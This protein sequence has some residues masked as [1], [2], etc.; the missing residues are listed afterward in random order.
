MTGHV[1]LLSTEPRENSVPNVIQTRQDTPCVRYASSWNDMVAT[2]ENDDIEL[3]LWKRGRISPV[4][5]IEDVTP[6][7][8]EILVGDKDDILS[9]FTEAFMTSNWS[10]VFHEIV[11]LDVQA[12]LEAIE[13]VVPGSQYRLKLLALS[14]DACR[15]F[16]QDRTFQRL[17]ITYRGRGAVW[18]HE[19][20]LTEHHATDMECVFLRGKRAGRDAKILH[21]SPSFTT[22]HPPRLVMVI[23]TL[24]SY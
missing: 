13:A 6:S 22:G 3:V 10:A 14:D 16:H 1:N 4:S 5:A 12:Y 9:G 21:K 15:K 7:E 19:D 2:A 8:F 18:R 23:D 11:K 24:P 20:S 17:I